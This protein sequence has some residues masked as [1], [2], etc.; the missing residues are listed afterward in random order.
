MIIEQNEFASIKAKFV[1]SAVAKLVDLQRE[2][3][4]LQAQVAFKQQQIDAALLSKNKIEEKYIAMV[5]IFGVED[6]VSAHSCG[7]DCAEHMIVIAGDA[8]GKE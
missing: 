8:L 3:K 2:M 4:L 7:D 1:G 5:E 6:I